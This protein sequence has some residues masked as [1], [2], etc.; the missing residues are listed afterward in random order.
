MKRVDVL[1]NEIKQSKEL[2][3]SLMRFSAD[4]GVLGRKLGKRYAM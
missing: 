1:R 2:I 3:T 4:D